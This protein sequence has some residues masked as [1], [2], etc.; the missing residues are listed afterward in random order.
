MFVQLFEYWIGCQFRSIPEATALFRTKQYAILA[1]TSF[2]CL[3]S[4][5][6]KHNH[7]DIE[8]SADDAHLFKTMQQNCAKFREAVKLF[9]MRKQDTEEVEE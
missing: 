2:I 7:A 6:P 5:V 9:R 4:M 8:L 1:P 3:L